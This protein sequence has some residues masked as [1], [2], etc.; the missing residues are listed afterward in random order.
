[1]LYGIF[2]NSGQRKRGGCLEDLEAQYDKIYR[3]CYFK[4]HNAHLAEDVT[5]EAFLKFWE[6]QSYKEMGKSMAYLYTIA[7]NL[8]VDTFRQKQA[9]PL[10]D[11]TLKG[12]GDAAETGFEETLTT[13]LAL[14]HA[15][16]GLSE[17]ERELLLLRYVNE[18][19]MAV[20]E[21][22]YGKSRFALRRE[23][24]RIKEKLKKGV[25]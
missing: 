11:E 19:P 16:E 12:F 20:L 23:L 25:V 22:M 14:H 18:A 15:M 10:S 13:Q 9:E 3:Y 24:K 7:R 21:K 4:L 8:C 5:Q 1:M 6:S 17:P 2:A